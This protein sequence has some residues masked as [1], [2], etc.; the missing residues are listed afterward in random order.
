[1]SKTISIGSIVKANRLKKTNFA[2]F[3][4]HFGNIIC[5]ILFCKL[6]VNLAGIRKSLADHT[7]RSMVTLLG[8]AYPQ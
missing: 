2:G 3:R 7:V 5:N 8:L 6:A 4:Q 1:L